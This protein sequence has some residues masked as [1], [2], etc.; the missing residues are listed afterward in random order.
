MNILYIILFSILY[1]IVIVG[2]KYLAMTI[3]NSEYTIKCPK[4]GAAMKYLDCDSKY[5]ELN[6]GDTFHFRPLIP[7]NILYI[8]PKCGCIKTILIDANNRIEK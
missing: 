4:C 3:I 1:V 7:Y 5:G 2:L 8:C 6:I